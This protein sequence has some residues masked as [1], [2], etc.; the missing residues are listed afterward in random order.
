MAWVLD[1]SPATGS[2]RLV[3]LAIANHADA[4]GHGAYPGLDRI[5]AEARVAR[6]TA[7]RSIT[8][9]EAAGQLRVVRGGG[10]Y[11]T[12]RY[13]IVMGPPDPP[14]SQ[15]APADT[16]PQEGC[17]S[18][19]VRPTATV[20]AT[21]PNGDSRDRKQCHRDTRTVLNRQEPSFGDGELITSPSATVEGEGE[22]DMI[23]TDA[24]SMLTTDEQARLWTSKDEG[25]R[26]TLT[27]TLAQLVAAGHDPHDLAL[28]LSEPMPA[29][30]WSPAAVMLTRARSIAAHDH[31]TAAARTVAADVADDREAD[32]A[33]LHAARLAAIADLTAEEV[34][35]EVARR[36]H[37]PAFLAALEHLAGL[38]RPDVATFAR[39]ELEATTGV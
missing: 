4:T 22:G 15:P 26:R 20:T 31:A 38:D 5:A 34:V 27:A 2:D 6:R 29:G 3:L 18:G 13:V 12:N 30:C 36:A 11:K 8:A 28:A 24:A 7:I 14:P 32:A 1:H 33:R 19:T 10:A 35:T 23:I 39:T 17:Q 21:A 25:C 9:L 16:P 37:G